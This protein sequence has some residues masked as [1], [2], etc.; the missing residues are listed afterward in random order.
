M[1]IQVGLALDIA[2][3]RGKVKLLKIKL[4]LY[5]RLVSINGIKFTVICSEF[6]QKKRDL[7]TAIT[8]GLIRQMLDIA[9]YR[10]KV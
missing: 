2:L 5:F 8:N 7:F 1:Y 6:N 4:K 3:Y 9:Q 10:G